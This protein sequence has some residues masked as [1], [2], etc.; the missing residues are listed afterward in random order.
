MTHSPTTPS[1]R[2]RRGVRVLA[3]TLALTLAGGAMA[4]GFPGRG[5]GPGP[6]WD[7]G[8][9]YERD[10]D[11]RDRADRWE[12]QERYERWDRDDRRDWRPGL[13]R[14]HAQWHRGGYVPA[15]Y[16]APQYVV[17]D[18]RARQLQAPPS[19]YQWMQINGDFVLGAIAGGLI[20]AIVAGQ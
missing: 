5:D 8:Q 15:S 19:G 7:Q 17:T 1:T 4:Q 14:P 16:R 6:R 3:A 2:T 18:W 9:R 11:R 20:A 12:R 13:P 10:H